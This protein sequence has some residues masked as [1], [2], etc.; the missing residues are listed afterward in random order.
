MTVSPT[1][2]APKID[3]ERHPF[4]SANE[5]VSVIGQG[6]WY[7][8]RGDRARAIA[9]LRKG[10]ELGMTHIDT[11]EYYGAAEDVVGEAIAGHRDQF[12]L[13]SKVVPENASR[14]G[15]IAACERSLAR[16]KTD[17]VDCYLL[18]WRGRHPLEDTIAAFEQLKRDGKIRFWGVSNF[19]VSDLEEI[20]AI[21]GP[22]HPVCNQVLYHLG[23]RTIEHDVVPWCE[24]H[25]VA[26]VGYSPFGHGKFPD[27]Q[28]SGRTRA[29]G[30]RGGAR[31]NR[32]PGRAWVPGQKHF[33][34]HHPQGLQSRALRGERRR[35]CFPADRSRGRS[36]R[37][38]VSAWSPSS[39]ASNAL[40][41]FSWGLHQG[42]QSP[43]H[44]LQQAS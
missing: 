24:K 37:R 6:T 32:P 11:A 42:G 18:H 35:R 30:N 39:R 22:G 36:N 20:R 40:K 41:Q 23:E 14:T 28:S 29:G 3:M 25:R 10:L 16:L 5:V 38:S 27:P 43:P 26:V 8:H 9:A 15:T 33:A 34:L 44:Q 4:G 2:S 13:V 17:R 12:F 31:S 19:D 21:A 1:K 7:L